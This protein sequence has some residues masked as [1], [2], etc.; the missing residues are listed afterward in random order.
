MNVWRAAPILWR[1]T[2]NKLTYG[3]RCVVLRF[4]QSLPVRPRFLLLSSLRPICPSVIHVFLVH[5]LHLCSFTLPDF[6]S[7]DLL[8]SIWILC[9]YFWT[10]HP[11]LNLARLAIV[12]LLFLC[13]FLMNNLKSFE[14]HQIQL[15]VSASGSNLFLVFLAQKVTTRSGIWTQH[16]DL[17]HLSYTLVCI[18][19]ELKRTQSKHLRICSSACNQGSIWEALVKEFTS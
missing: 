16:T 11:V 1:A 3:R 5:L 4:V 19:G 2:A 14:T 7:L 9:D 10:A 12:S 13:F 17:F 15:P 6:W 18:Y 8:P